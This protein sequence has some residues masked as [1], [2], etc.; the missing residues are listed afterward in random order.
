MLEE[1]LRAGSVIH[2]GEWHFREVSRAFMVSEVMFSQQTKSFSDALMRFA[3]TF[4]YN[5]NPRNLDKRLERFATADRGL[6]MELVPH[7]ESSACDR[8]NQFLVDL[9]NWLAP[10]AGPDLNDFGQRVGTGVNVF[11]Y[12]DTPPGSHSL[13]RFRPIA[14]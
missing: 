14:P 7:F 13:S 9:D 3:R 8:A 1:P 11:L 10:Y 12:V 4:D 6:P 5:C 2:S